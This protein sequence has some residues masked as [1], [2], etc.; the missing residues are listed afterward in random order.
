MSVIL[1]AAAIALSGCTT[2]YKPSLPASSAPLVAENLVGV[3]EQLD[4]LPVETTVLNLSTDAFTKD[5][6]AIALRRSLEDAGYAIRISGFATGEQPVS[7]SVT[8]R[9]DATVGPVITYTVSAGDISVRR[10][11]ATAEDGMLKPI[12]AMQVRGADASQV[13][14]NDE[15]FSRQDKLVSGDLAIQGKTLQPL[16]LPTNPETTKSPAAIEPV[17]PE[18]PVN[19]PP[20]AD[21]LAQTPVDTEQLVATLP[22]AT[23][24]EALPEPQVPSRSLLDIA[25]PSMAKSAQASEKFGSIERLSA[26]PKQNVRDLGESNFASVFDDFGIVDEA[27][28]R[29]DNDSVRMGQ[30]NKYR[31]QRF[32]E[33]FKVD[34]DVLSVIGCSNGP[35]SLAIGQE[36]LALG[37]AA[38]VKEELLYAGVPEANILEEG[39][40]AEDYFDN[41]MPRRGVVLTLK[42]RVPAS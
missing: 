22:S 16:V 26:L 33:Q 21:V 39:C 29:F 41:R 36:G 1:L 18:V 35:T 34:S 30:G 25:A 11:Y 31:V 23:L 24:Q 5:E 17:Q 42:R 9:S 4:R 37:R 28:L 38:R 10:S 40:W 3:L 13:T 19:N 20:A 2:L 27:I 6:F 14:V 12:A 8:K 15:L 7:F 32:V